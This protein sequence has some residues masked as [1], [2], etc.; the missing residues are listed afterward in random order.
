[1]NEYLLVKLDR[2]PSLAAESVDPE[3]VKDFYLTR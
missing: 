2:F 3:Y 1:M